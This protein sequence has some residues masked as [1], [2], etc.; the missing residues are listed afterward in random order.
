MSIKRYTGTSFVEVGSRKRFN[1]T[2]WVALSF[3]KRW[4]GSAWV[5][6]WSDSQGSG[7]SS[8]SSGGS[9]TP[10]STTASGALFTNVKSTVSSPTVCYSAEYVITRSGASASVALTF[11]G[12]LNSSASHLGS[13]IKLTVFARL[14]GGVWENSVIKSGSAV[15]SGTTKHSASITFSGVKNGRNKLEFYITRAG[16]SYSGSA[17]SIGSSSNPKTYYIN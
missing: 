5:D 1:G 11:R 17:G 12:W 9:G 4:N 7:D 6:L 10:V 3:G 14:N 2:A 15:W 16:S 8:G 13:G